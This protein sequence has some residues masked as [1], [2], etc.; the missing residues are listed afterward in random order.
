VVAVAVEQPVQERRPPRDRGEHGSPRHRESRQ[1]APVRTA[2]GAP[3]EQPRPPRGD[4]SRPQRGERP[5][6]QERPEGR[7][8]QQPRQAK[9][10]RQPWEPRPPRSPDRGREDRG[11][12]PVGLGDHVPAFLKKTTRTAT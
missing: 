8:P 7:P 2:R 11:P 6:R 9:Q 12:S 4:R 5:A 10:A 1:D 3:E